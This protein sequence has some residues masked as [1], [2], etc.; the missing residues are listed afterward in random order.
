MNQQLGVL[1][2]SINRSVLELDYSSR[3]IVSRGEQLETE[4]SPSNPERRQEWIRD[5]HSNGKRLVRVTGKL[6]SFLQQF[7]IEEQA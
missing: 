3:M 2:D 1:F 6:Q 5:I 7:R 4:E